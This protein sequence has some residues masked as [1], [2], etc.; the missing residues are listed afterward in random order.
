MTLKWRREKYRSRLRSL[1][2]YTARAFDGT[3]WVAP[4]D[5]GP[6]PIDQFSRLRCALNNRLTRRYE[7]LLGYEVFWVR[8][9]TGPGRRRQVWAALA[10]DG[11]ARAG[12]RF[13][14]Q[15]F[16]ARRP[17]SPPEIEE[18]HESTGYDS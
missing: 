11:S 15:D 3:Y 4:V 5:C 8:D 1:P 12:K 17:P 2:V 6:G 13:A 18:M 10:G 9:G 7:R 14:E 16:E